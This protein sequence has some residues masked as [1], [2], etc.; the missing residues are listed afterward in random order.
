MNRKMA[1]RVTAILTAVLFLLNF[2]AAASVEKG[3]E[4]MKKKKYREAVK[5]YEKDLKKRPNDEELIAKIARAYDGAKWYGQ[6]VQ[7]WEDYIERFPK[8]KNLKEAKKQAALARRWIGVNFYVNGEGLGLAIN[9]LEKAVKWDPKLFEGWYWLARARMEKGDCAGANEAAKSALA[10]APD[11]AKA[12]WLVKETGGCARFGREA[13][14]AYTRGYALYE[15]GDLAGA[16][17]E[18][19]KAA[20]AEPDFAAAHYW[21][22]R[23]YM[24]QGDKKKALEEWKKTLALDPDNSRAKWFLEKTKRMPDV[25]DK[26][27][28]KPE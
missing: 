25:A 16:L 2:T 3:D 21:L 27:T 15:K 26:P 8:G 19:R 5:E 22:G 24:E 23:I 17:A 4:L 28:S 20:A 11:D 12:K 1:L 6:A 14:A 9:E 18:Y 13:F 7:R 10:A